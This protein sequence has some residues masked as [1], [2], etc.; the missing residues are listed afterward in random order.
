MASVSSARGDTTAHVT[1][2]TTAH[3]TDMT[4]GTAAANVED[5]IKNTADFNKGS[6]AGLDRLAQE[7]QQRLH[8]QLEDKTELSRQHMETQMVSK[9]WWSSHWLDFLGVGM[10]IVGAFMVAHKFAQRAGRSEASDEAEENDAAEAAG[11]SEASDEAEENDA[12]VDE[13][14]TTGEASKGEVIPGSLMGLSGLLIVVGRRL[15]FFLTFGQ[16]VD[17][18]TKGGLFVGGFG[19]LCSGGA[20]C[21]A[22]RSNSSSWGG[23]V[24]SA[25]KMT[26]AL[27]VTSLWMQKTFVVPMVVAVV[28]GFCHWIAEG[29]RSDMLAKLGLLVGVPPLLYSGGMRC[30]KGCRKQAW[31][32]SMNKLET[33]ALYVFA[34]SFL[35]MKGGAMLSHLG[36]I[37]EWAVAAGLSL[38]GLVT[39]EGRADLLAKLG[40]ILG[41]VMLLY[42]I[43]ER[44]CAKGDGS[45]WNLNPSE[46]TSVILLALSSL[47]VER[48]WVLSHPVEMSMIVGAV[49]VLCETI[50]RCKNTGAVTTGERNRR[51]IGALILIG[52]SLVVVGRYMLHFIEDSALARFLETHLAS[53]DRVDLLAKFGLTIGGIM[54]MCAIAWRFDSLMLSEVAADAVVGEEPTWKAPLRPWEINVLRLTLVS[55]GLLVRDRWFPHLVN[56]VADFSRKIANLNTQQLDVLRTTSILGIFLMK[57]TELSLRL[58]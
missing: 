9:K 45:R 38:L 31:N 52:G 48:E 47:W 57:F 24:S 23:P 58:L 17:F 4:V 10:M 37:K 22:M 6:D 7:M 49:S 29:E 20:R 14:K 50:F 21:Y 1:G 12:A 35:W 56:F 28:R 53:G 34:V 55:F 30:L 42:R 2:D 44:C 15:G 43:G 13:N 39:G 40:V 18:L 41:G 19:V 5:L 11:R 36:A 54:G 33:T 3:V 26:A 27:F 46:I 25:E 51:F 32:Q 16:I 8:D